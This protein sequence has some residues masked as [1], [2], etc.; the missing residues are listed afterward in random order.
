MSEGQSTPRWVASSL[1]TQW[2]ESRGGS[3]DSLRD[4]YL[5]S[6]PDWDDR[7]RA[8]LTELLYGVTRHLP[9]IDSRLNELLTTTVRQMQPKLLS[10]L[11]IGLY[12]LLYLDRIPDHAAVDEAVQQAKRFGGKKAG[13]LVNAVLRRAI[14]E[15]GESDGD[16]TTGGGRFD[17]WRVKWADQWGD[18]KATSLIEFFATVPPLGLRRNLLRSENDE[19]W[20]NLLRDEGV[21]PILIP[22]RPGYV[23]ARGVRPD[24]LESFENGTTTV[25]DPGAGI[26]VLIL[27]PQPGER[28]LDLC[29]APGGKAAAIWERMGGE[30]ELLTIDR[31]AG[32]QER[33]KQTLERLG[34]T[35]VEVVTADLLE[36]ETTPGDRVLIDVPCSGTGWRIVV[37]I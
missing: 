4:R 22:N 14:R 27:D 5:K 15:R 34:H 19:Q 16:K 12:Q 2:A 6:A 11:R 33:T 35:G 3:I 28:I 1:L 17:S 7:D 24:A 9:E 10:I 26:P 30:G 13:G 25:Q 8:L 32:R 20:L 21:D 29:G 18:E 36:F 23:H 37:Q 31:E